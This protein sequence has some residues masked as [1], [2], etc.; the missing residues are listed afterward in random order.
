MSRQAIEDRTLMLQVQAEQAKRRG[1]EDF[2]ARLVDRCAR[3]EVEN[4]KLKR[5]LRRLEKEGRA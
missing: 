4:E 5:L 2:A 1:V 3:L